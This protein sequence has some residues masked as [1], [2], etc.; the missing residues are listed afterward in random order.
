M[1]APP[2]DAP[3]DAVRRF[4]EAF[5]RDD[6]HGMQAAC[7]DATSIVDDFPPH[8]WSGPRAITR[9][10]GEMAGMASGEGMSDWSVTLGDPRRVVIS[11]EAA[12]VAVDADVRWREA[13][14][15]AERACRMAL[16]LQLDG[17]GWRISAL[18]WAWS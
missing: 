1:A 8:A 7:T 16:S 13:G 11:G 18:A 6:V 3:M 17:D 12:Y 5:N 15:P 14:T 10:Y 4:V 2:E 9:W